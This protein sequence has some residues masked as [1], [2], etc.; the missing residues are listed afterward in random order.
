MAQQ[1]TVTA[2]GLFLAPNDLGNVPDGAL[3]QA[4]NCVISKDGVVEQ[5]RGMS[6]AGTRGIVRIFPW[7]NYIVGW[8]ASGVLSRS[9]DSGAT[10]TDYGGTYA[11]PGVGKVRS[12]DASGNFYF[13]TS[14]GPYRLDSFTGTPEP[15]GIPSGLD[16]Q[17]DLTTAGGTAIPADTQVAY[18]VLWGKRDANGNLLLGAPSGRVTVTNVGAISI[19]IAGIARVGT[20]VTV[21]I[22]AGHTYQTGNVVTMTSAGE[23]NFANGSKTVTGITTTTFTYTEAGAAASSTAAQTFLGPTRDATV[24]ATIP[25]GLPVGAFMQA[26]RSNNS[27]SATLVPDDNLGLVYEG[28]PPTSKVTSQFSRTGSTVTVTTTTDHGYSAGQMVNV[29]ASVSGAGVMVA[30]GASVAAS[31]SDFGATWTARTIPAG[32]YTA[33]AWSGAKFCAVGDSAICATSADGITWAVQ[34]DLATKVPG[35]AFKAIAWNG[36]VFCAVGSGTVCATSTNG[37][38]WTSRTISAGNWY[39]LAWSGIQFAACG[40]QAG[41]NGAATS[42]DGTTWTPRTLPWLGSSS[43]GRVM[44]LV[45]DGTRFVGAGYVIMAV[46]AYSAAVWESADGI[47][48]SGS[49]ILTNAPDNAKSYQFTSLA[50]SGAIY[51]A[52]VSGNTPPYYY[53]SSDRVTFTGRTGDGGN[54]YWDGAKFSAAGTNKIQTSTDG[55]TWADV[56]L[57]TGSYVALCSNAVLFSAGDKTLV[58][59]PSTTSFTY[60]EPGVA[61]TISAT[62]TI[63]PLTLGFT[64]I[65]PSSFLGAALYTN[66]NQGTLAASADRVLLCQDIASFRGFTFAANITYPSRAFVYMVAAPTV[67]DTVTVDGTVYAAGATGGG[68]TRTFLAPSAGTPAQNIASAAQSLIRV[69]NRSLSGTVT[70]KYLSGPDDVPGYIYL[71]ENNTSTTMTL[72]FSRSTAWS[73]QSQKGPENRRN[74]IRWSSSGQPDAWP[75]LNAQSLGSLDKPVSA[76]RATRDMLVIVK[77]DGIWRLTGWNG[78]WDIQPLDP[79]M[80]TPAPETLVAFENAVFGVLDSGVARLTESG[81]EMISTPIYSAIET[82]L[83]PASEPTLSSTAFGLAYHSAHKYILW[84]PSAAGD[85]VSKQAYVYD[86]WTNTWARWLPPTGVTGWA[87]GMVNQAS[88]DDRLYMLDGTSVYAENK[89]L[90]ASDLHDGASTAIPMSV[91]F[92]PKFGGNPGQLHHFQEVSFIFRQAKWATATVG[93]STNVSPAEETVTLPGSSYGIDTSTGTQ[94]TIRVLVPLEKARGS[95]LNVRFS[96]SEANAQVQLQG[97]SVV[98]RPGSTRVSR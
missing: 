66:P 92:C 13:T 17:A 10:W 68:S 94:T 95:Q 3:A 40:N 50:F 86:S 43:S 41:A 1:V 28:A 96:H 83:A 23:A 85:T 20:T 7:K 2:T 6:V 88:A 70:A 36:T 47:T 84:L 48:W 52:S 61:G 4:D 82:L 57:P 72:A 65:I 12:A 29:S 87:H 60:L 54:V 25:Q 89:A 73:I 63:V 38:T 91:K 98:Y 24:T 15:A 5:R 69:I 18:R 97:I 81:V 21:T 53:I 74:E 64:D 75:L 90:S 8:A 34:T 49:V 14:L 35:G 76:I 45:H 56:T 30:V 59:A 31:S 11:G 55:A 32:T 27:Q 80:G 39:S 26:Y 58:S 78:V 19:P 37:I 16:V 22:A 51:A 42:P 62:R 9:S 33:V 44:Q 67:G 93:F 79:T 77:D 46:G 71:E